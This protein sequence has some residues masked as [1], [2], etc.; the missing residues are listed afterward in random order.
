MGAGIN[1]ADTFVQ[2]G[3]VY[4][5]SELVPEAKGHFIKKFKLDNKSYNPN[6]NQVMVSRELAVRG[7]AKDT[8]RYDFGS[9]TDPV[10]YEEI[11]YTVPS[12]NQMDLITQDELLKKRVG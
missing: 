11:L 8:E 12:H 3:E 7:L 1:I 2:I 6:G 9:G 10:Y 4:K 5:Q